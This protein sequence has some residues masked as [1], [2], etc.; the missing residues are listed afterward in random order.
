MNEQE[1]EE[2]LQEAYSL[3]YGPGR[4]AVIED[5]IRSADQHEYLHLAF[6]ARRAIVDSAS[7]SARWELIPVHFAWLLAMCDEHPHRF[8]ERPVVYEYL[9]AVQSLA[10]FTGVRKEDILRS[11]EDITKR[12]VKLGL[13]LDE[14]HR[15]FFLNAIEMGELDRANELLDQLTTS[16][17]FPTAAV[18]KSV[19][20]SGMFAYRFYCRGWFRVLF[21]DIEKG[22]HDLALV[23]DNQARDTIMHGFALSIALPVLLQTDRHDDLATLSKRCQSEVAGRREMVEPYTEFVKFLAMSGNWDELIIRWPEYASYGEE[24]KNELDHLGYLQAATFVVDKL[25]QDDAIS[26]LVW[27]RSYTGPK[28]SARDV[29]QSFE[30][31]TEELAQRFDERN[32]NDY[33]RKRFR[34]SRSW[35]TKPFPIQF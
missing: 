29:L 33:Y 1:I 26:K 20:P 9:S 7:L 27:P 10:F 25:G 30:L 11:H 28:E 6:E 32:E 31:R 21:G 19:A 22:L 8:D 24:V 34:E 5:A 23:Y 12:F 17:Y 15:I 4:I 16:G 35:E 3:P 13:N 2:K 14:V 18:E